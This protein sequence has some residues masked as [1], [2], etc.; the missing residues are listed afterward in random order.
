MVRLRA[1][2]SSIVQDDGIAPSGPRDG[3]AVVGLLLREGED[4]AAVREERAVAGTKVHVARIELGEVS[5]DQHH[6]AT[7]ARAPGP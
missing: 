2:S 1:P 5:H 3:D 7:L 4:V 6:A